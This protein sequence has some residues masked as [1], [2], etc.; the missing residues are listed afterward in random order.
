VSRR[1]LI[2]RLFGLGL[3]FA[4]ACAQGAPGGGVGAVIC[5]LIGSAVNGASGTPLVDCT[6][7]GSSSTFGGPMNESEAVATAP[8]GTCTANPGNNACTGCVETSC[9]AASLACLG[10]VACKCLI[11]C[12]STGET[13]DTCTATCKAAPDATTDKMAACVLDNCPAECPGFSP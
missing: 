9:C 6:D 7:S 3:C 10:D 1:V 2:G 4:L 12:E 8:G 5:A 11:A 13:E